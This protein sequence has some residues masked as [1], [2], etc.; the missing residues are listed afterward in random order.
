MKKNRKNIRKLIEEAFKYYNEKTL[1]KEE[2]HQYFKNKGMNEK[3]I[4]ELIK[5]ALIHNIIEV[6]V[7]P[8]VEE[9]EEMPPK[10]IKTKIAYSLKQ[11]LIKLG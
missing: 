3:E 11:K 5:Q 7:A 9:E 4:K 1:F 10:E 8:I 2:I 6:G